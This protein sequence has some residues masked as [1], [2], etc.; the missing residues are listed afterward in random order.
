MSFATRLLA[1]LTISLL[2]SLAAAD[3]AANSDAPDAFYDHHIA[4]QVSDNDPGTFT[5]V[6]NNA[7]NMTKAF[8]DAGQNVEIRIIAWNGGLDMLRTDK[9]PEVERIEAFATSM[10]NI[11]FE[12]CGNTIAGVTKKEGKAP[13]LVPNA[14]VVPGGI[15]EAIKLSENGWTLIRP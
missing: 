1:V 15:V 11:K 13:P 7:T 12:A 3:D 9:S 14:S 2:P 5:K 4:L 8:S 10:P 6:L